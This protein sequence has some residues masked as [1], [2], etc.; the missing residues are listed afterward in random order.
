M[1]QKMTALTAAVL[2]AAIILT[3][4]FTHAAD[5]TWEG[6]DFNWTEPDSSSFGADTYNSGDD[7]FFSGS[8]EGT[9]TVQSGGVNP[10][11]ANL[12]IGTYQFTGGTVNASA[13]NVSGGELQ[14]NN[15]T[16][17][18]GGPINVMDDATLRSTKTSSQPTMSSSAI[19]VGEGVTMDFYMHF[20][21]HAGSPM[22]APITGG[23]AA[24]PITVNF[25]HNVNQGRL[26]LSPSTF[27]GN[28]HLRSRMILSP[29]QDNH[30]GDP[31]NTLHVHGS[32]ETYTSNVTLNRPVT[33]H[34]GFLGGPHTAPIIF[35]GPVTNIAV[36]PSV[37]GGIRFN[38][39]ASTLGNLYPN[40]GTIEFGYL[41]A[42]GGSRSDGGGNNG[43]TFRFLGD[44][45]GNASF[46]ISKNYDFV[47]GVA[48]NRWM[49]LD[50]PSANADVTLTSA[51]SGFQASR[52]GFRKDGAGALTLAANG[53]NIGAF[54]VRGGRLYV[55][56]T[57]SGVNDMTVKDGAVLGGNG[58]ISMN[59]GST[60]TVDGSLGPGK[61][62]GILTVTGD[63]VFG[64]T[65]A[66]EVE[67]NDMTAAGTGYDRLVV[68]PDGSVTIN[69]GAQLLPIFDPGL[70]A[71]LGDTVYILDNQG[72]DPILGTFQAGEGEFVGVYG[73][74]P[75][76]ITYQAITDTALTGGNDIALVAIPEPASGLLL[77]LAGLGL[78]RRRPK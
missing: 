33:I 60:L 71:A 42:G 17:L 28:V 21:G 62:T 69:S 65:G 67:I 45:V 31:S 20:N 77:A 23:S 50:V 37:I 2:T 49:Y 30:F 12:S 46:G 10:N 35:D 41:P 55:D 72:A 47:D 6:V 57:L 27:A 52:G 29:L 26:A 8:G 24:D 3:R 68:G 54:E 13:W 11:T 74:M 39:P 53:S 32:L 70:T 1:T 44:L 63:V 22:V 25:Y 61:S 14:W 9:I 43:V 16:V 5:V 78:L 48:D 58:S 7:V 51:V 19:N 76:M 15:D 56:A 66:F 73:G 38:N 59:P 36:Q 75:W 40:G 34:S 64:Q 4:G 18:G